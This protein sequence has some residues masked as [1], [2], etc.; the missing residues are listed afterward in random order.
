MPPMCAS[1]VAQGVVYVGGALTGL[2]VMAA[3][4]R[5]RRPAG[6][7]TVTETPPEV[8]PAAAPDAPPPGERLPAPAG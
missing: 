1:C 8:A 5:A 4:A 7:P 2:Q 3:R 6:A